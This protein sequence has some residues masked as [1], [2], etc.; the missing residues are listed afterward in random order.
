[1]VETRILRIKTKGTREQCK[2]S[3]EMIEAICDIEIEYIQMSPLSKR[4]IDLLK[5]DMFN[6]SFKG[7]PK[8]WV[9]G[10]EMKKK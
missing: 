8:G 3:W 4:Q 7:K 2:Q 1:M 9:F 10:K 6:S 5:A